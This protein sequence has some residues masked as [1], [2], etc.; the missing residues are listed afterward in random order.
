MLD[1]VMVRREPVLD[2]PQHRLRPAGDVDLAV[3]AANVGLDGVGAEIGQLRDFGVAFALRDQRQ[4]LGFTVAEAL[5][6]PRPV[7]PWCAACSRRSFTDDR[8]TGVN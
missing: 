2:A 8:L 7:E 5:A 4:Y 6:P 3:D 1:P